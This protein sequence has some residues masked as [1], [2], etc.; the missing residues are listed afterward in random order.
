[1]MEQATA[2]RSIEQSKIK[3]QKVQTLI[4]KWQESHSK[5]WASE[6]LPL[7]LHEES[8][9]FYS[10]QSCWVRHSQTQISYT[11]EQI[12]QLNQTS[13]ALRTTKRSKKL[14][15]PTLT[16]PTYMNTHNTKMQVLK[17]LNY[18]T[19]TNQSTV[20]VKQHLINLTNIWYTHLSL[21]LSLSPLPQNYTWLS[22]HSPWPFLCIPELFKWGGRSKVQIFWR[23]QM[24][25]FTMHG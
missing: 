8:Q 21:K 24:A 2:N 16:H 14:N 12:T 5:D 6:Q 25:T 17:G 23:L 9:A 20:S 15:K 19:F 18:S 3:V 7:T 1:M 13:Q 11:N 10:P 22:C 4:V